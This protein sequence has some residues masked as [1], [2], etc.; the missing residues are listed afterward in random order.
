M[1]QDDLGETELVLDDV[2]KR[3]FIQRSKVGHLIQRAEL[4]YLVVNR[5]KG[6]LKFR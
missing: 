3:L 6:A 1:H 5:P 2:S 4:Y